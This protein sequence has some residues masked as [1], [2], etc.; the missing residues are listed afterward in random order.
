MARSGRYSSN[1]ASYIGAYVLLI[2]AVFV[3]HSG[4]P[5]VLHELGVSISRLCSFT[6]FERVRKFSAC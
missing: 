6:F 4:S 2:N 3:N 5:K 1:T